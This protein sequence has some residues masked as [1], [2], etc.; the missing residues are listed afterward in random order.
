M[1]TTPFEG[2]FASLPRSPSCR[3]K[4]GPNKR[5]FLSRYEAAPKAALDRNWSGPNRETRPPERRL[6]PGD[7]QLRGV[8][9]AAPAALGTVPLERTVDKRVFYAATCSYSN[10]LR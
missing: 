1:A 6:V 3:S 2:W 10:G 4:P 9:I 5:V 8:D 7:Q